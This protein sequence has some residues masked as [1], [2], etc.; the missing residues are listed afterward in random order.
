MSLQTPK[1]IGSLSESTD[2]EETPG[3][4][5]QVQNAKRLEAFA[6]LKTKAPVPSTPAP[7]PSAG[8]F[9]GLKKP[10]DTKLPGPPK[11]PPDQPDIN[12]LR[13]RVPLKGNGPKTNRVPAYLDP[14]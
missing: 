7:A 10:T 9:Q 6:G 13:K 1:K 3:N 2:P 14:V 12:F 8:P 4:T 5:R 11:E